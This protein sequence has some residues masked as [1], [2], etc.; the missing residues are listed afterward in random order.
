MSVPGYRGN[1]VCPKCRTYT[2]QV[3]VRRG[4]RQCLNCGIGFKLKDVER[5]QGDKIIR[6][7]P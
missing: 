1:A 2:Q 3:I 4:V 7:K 5:I 6:P